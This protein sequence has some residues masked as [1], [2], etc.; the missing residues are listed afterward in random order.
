M[1]LAA[2]LANPPAKTGNGP[3]CSVGQALSSLD[4]E[5]ADAFRAA[6]EDRQRWE[7]QAL[8]KA[9]TSDGGPFI[10]EGA[11]GKHRRGQCGC[12]RDAR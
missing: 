2:K 12:F 6:L 7:E 9:V 5:S 1:N 11:I 4:R 10:G 8:K 3:K